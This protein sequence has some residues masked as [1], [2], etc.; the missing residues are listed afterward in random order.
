MNYILYLLLIAVIFG[1]IALIDFVTKRLFAPLR[2]THDGPVV[3]MPRYS[4]ILGLLLALVGLIAV[5]YMPTDETFLYLGC[6]LVLAI[7]IYLLI[8]FFW[9]GVF[10]DNEG[11]T[12]R[13]FPRKGRYYRYEEIT[14]Q[15]SFV[16]KSGWNTALYANGQEIQLYAAMQG[17]PEFLLHAFRRWCLQKGLDPDEV[18]HDA[19]TLRFFPEPEEAEQE[20]EA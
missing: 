19:A 3:R 7:G 15:R 8:N 1:L 4:F 11:F 14:S 9:T 17:V 10:Y 20:P 12:Y 5:L 18:E 2:K 6:W 16:A 13:A